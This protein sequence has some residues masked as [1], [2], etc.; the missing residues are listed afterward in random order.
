MALK[1]LLIEALIV[2]NT[3]STTWK[4]T[5]NKYQNILRHDASTVLYTSIW[6]GNINLRKVRKKKN[7]K[8]N[9]SRHI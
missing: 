9:V 7:L 3:H 8:K 4:K 2:G 5:R 6:V 1:P